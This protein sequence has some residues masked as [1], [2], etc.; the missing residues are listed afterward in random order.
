MRASPSYRVRMTQPPPPPPGYG[1]PQPP[2]FQ[3]P[4]PPGYASSDEKTWALLTHF[5]AAAGVLFSGL[6][7]WVMPLVT[8]LA[9][10]KESPTL[11]AHAVQALN[12]N[13][14]WAAIDLL[15]LILG[16]CLNFVIGLPFFLGLIYLVP[17]IFNIIAGMKANEGTVY[18]FPISYPL[19]K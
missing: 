13:I 1:P 3:G 9:K 18:R 7:G 11:R 5:L 14:L 17:L 19:I 2:H 4:P 16:S 10:G 8:Y 12:F 15:A 6:L